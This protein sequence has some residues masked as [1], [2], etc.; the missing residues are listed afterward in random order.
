MI[1]RQKPTIATLDTGAT[2]SCIQISIIQEHN[3]I[4]EPSTI[5][6]LQLSD[7]S[8]ITIMGQALLWFTINNITFQHQFLVLTQC[9]DSVLLGADFL[10]QMK[11]N[12]VI[13]NSDII[14]TNKPGIL[15]TI[16]PRTSRITKTPVLLQTF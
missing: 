9:L 1:I 12:L 15:N 6:F 11:C 3:I 13:G 14:I 2:H 16:F 5:P 7:G 10:R 4:M 8:T